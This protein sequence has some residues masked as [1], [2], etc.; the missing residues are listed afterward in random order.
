MV[1]GC[2]EVQKLLL[3]L[4]ASETVEMHVHGFGAFCMIV[5][6]MTLTMVELSTLFYMDG[7]EWPTLMRV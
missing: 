1:A 3:G 5:L 2:P 6:L 7:C 4:S